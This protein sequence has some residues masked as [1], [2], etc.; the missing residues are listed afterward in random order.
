MA[1]CGDDDDD[2]D[3]EREVGRGVSAQPHRCATRVTRGADAPNQAHSAS[4][5]IPSTREICNAEGCD[6]T[7]VS[8]YTLNITTIDVKHGVS[9]R[10]S[11]AT[12]RV[13]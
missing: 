8:V 7:H 9:S 3:E 13:E 1:W 11:A 10:V 2:S 12:T 6:T 5:T 4:C